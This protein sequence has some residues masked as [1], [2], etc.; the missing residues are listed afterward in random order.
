VENDRRIIFDPF[1]LDL[2]DESLSRGSKAIKLRP[3][4]FAVLDRL[5]AS[6]RQLVTKEQLL[7]A[8]WPETYVGEA[9]L[10]VAIRQIRDALDDDPKAPRFIETVHRRGYRFIG[11]I[12]PGVEVS[13]EGQAM[14]VKGYSSPLRSADARTGV[15]GRHH[16]LAQ[17]GTCLDKMLRGESQMVFLTG[18]AGIGKTALVEAFIQGPAFDGS[19]RVARGHSLEHYGKAEAYLPVLEAIGRLCREDVQVVDVL[20]AHAPMWLLQMPSLVSASDRE[21]LNREVIGATRERMLREMAET[22]DVLSADRPLVLILEDLHWSDYSTLDLISYLGRRRQPAQLMLVGTYRIV[23]L[24]LSGHPLKGVK[25]ELLAKQQCVELQL[26]YLNKDAVAQYL[27]YRFSNHR[28]PPALAALIQERTEGNPLFMINAVDYLVTAGLIAADEGHWQLTVAVEKVEVGVP[29]SIKQ[30]IDKQVDHFSTEEQRTLEAASVAGAEFSTLA[31]A[32]ALGE[33]PSVIEARF[34]Q[35]ARR[36]HFVRDYGVQ[37]LPNGEAVG[38]YGFVHALYQNVLYDRISAA[39]RVQLHRRIAEKGEQIYGERAGEI[40]A[41]LAMHFEK[42]SNLNKAARYL[43]RTADNAVRRFAYPEA[44]AISRRG[45][46]LLGKLPDSAERAEQELCLQLTLGV[47]LIA[48]E[49]YAA[50]DVGNVY[51]RARELCQKL[52]DTPDISE[53]L[54]G[55]WTFYILRAELKTA[56]EIAQ[57]LLSLAERLPYP[58]L[59]MRGHLMVG[60]SQFHLGEFGP[61][62]EALEKALSLYNPERHLDDAV[63]YSQH[64]G[65]AMQCFAAWTLWFLGRPEQALQRMDEALAKAR[66][67]SE[68]NGLAHAFLFAAVLHQLRGD[69]RTSQEHAEAGIAVSTEHGLIMYLAQTTIIHAWTLL[70]QGDQ[71]EAIARMDHGLAAYQ[72][73]GTCLLRPQFLALRARAC[74]ATDQLVEGIR[75]MDESL[76]TAHRT[77]D[78]CYLAELYRIKGDLL[79]KQFPAQAETCFEQAK[80]IAEQQQARSWELRAV[81]SLARLYRQQGKR[82]QAR[83]LLAEIYERFTEGFDTADLR[84]AKALLDQLSLPQSSTKG[85]KS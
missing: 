32:A 63:F 71:Q 36:R 84:A 72:T 77:G 16:P 55:L 25:Q 22:L 82:E 14:G 30:M 48:S 31:V 80:E 9:V 47:P 60:V 21:L 28:F 44:V 11:Q 79:L 51:L 23:E 35:C 2:A 62:I 54:W 45:L 76:E 19:I 17:L 43:Q 78:A 27:S 65:V 66:E 20:R 12:T 10:K 4:A 41:E 38:R 68:P 73:S 74:E 34:E 85:T 18:E 33:E 40:A 3:K 67:L 53:V 58:G 39:R 8:V 56:H 6:A 61:A 83:T 50:A 42:G 24:I 49:G 59:A 26:E 7:N 64:P 13:V 57:E 29:E 75:L 5:V 1:C 46:E 52:G 70:E 81:T 69:V 15:V 37:I